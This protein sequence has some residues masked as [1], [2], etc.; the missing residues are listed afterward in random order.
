MCGS[1]KKKPQFNLL[2]QHQQPKEELDELWSGIQAEESDGNKVTVYGKT[3]GGT[4][5]MGIKPAVLNLTL[6]NGACGCPFCLQEGERCG[7][8]WVYPYQEEITL[9]TD[10]ELRTDGL[11]VWIE[12]LKSLNGIKGMTTMSEIVDR[13]I[14]TTAVD[15]MHNMF[16]GHVDHLFLLLFDSSFA[17]YDFSLAAHTETMNK[18]LNRQTPPNFIE[19]L[20]KRIELKSIWKA[21]DRK[22]WLFYYSLPILQDLISERQFECQ[23]LLVYGLSKLNSDS[24]SEEDLENA[25]VALKKYVKLFEEIYGHEQMRINVHSIQHLGNVVMQAMLFGPLWVTSCLPW[26]NFYGIMSKW[27]HGSRE[28]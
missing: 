19:G 15:V 22:A 8:T 26:E 24:I 1:A 11:T 2:L 25:R 12:H 16:V 28:P 6:W 9:R 3:I 7:N 23:K 13:A 5:D 21:H 18:F 27:I 17:N 10:E 14:P 20:P 4:C